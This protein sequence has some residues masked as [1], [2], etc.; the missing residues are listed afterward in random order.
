MALT[1]SEFASSV[2]AARADSL[3]DLACGSRAAWRPASPSRPGGSNSGKMCLRIGRCPGLSVA[4]LGRVTLTSL[5]ARWCALLYGCELTAAVAAFAGAGRVAAFTDGCPQVVI[6]ARAAKPAMTGPP[7]DADR[8]NDTEYLPDMRQTASESRVR[9]QEQPALSP[10]AY[11][12]PAAV[13]NAQKE[14]ERGFSTMPASIW[15]PR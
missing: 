6:S 14:A 2:L 4:A 10:C 11:T 9:P 13:S 15:P 7:R 3:V 8:R 5:T 12:R 1:P